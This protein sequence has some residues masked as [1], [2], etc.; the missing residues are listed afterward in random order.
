MKRYSH[1]V[2]AAAAVLLSGACLSPLSPDQQTAP[3][4]VF[5]VPSAFADLY[6]EAD[7]LRFRVTRPPGITRDT[8][9]VTAGPDGSI[10]ARAVLRPEEGQPGTVI[11]VAVTRDVTPLFRGSLEV[12]EEPEPSI[13]ILLPLIPVGRFDAGPDR[14]VPVGASIEL[15]S[16]AV[17]FLIGTS[18]TP[19]DVAW[20]SADS[21]VVRIDGSTATG[22]AAGLTR[23]YGV[24]YGEVDSLTVEVEAS[25]LAGSQPALTEEGS[26]AGTPTEANGRGN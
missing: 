8:A 3:S 23:V 11:D 19:S 6:Q 7:G 26:G 4:I 21:T 18:R 5:V 15:D 14:A 1:R 17:T 22:I 10:R 13:D 9:L 12:R 20:V 2:L 24:W 16:A 25:S